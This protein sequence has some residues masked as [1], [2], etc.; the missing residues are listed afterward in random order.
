MSTW[1]IVLL[2][3]AALV[4][5]VLVL[6]FLRPKTSLTVRSALIDAPPERIYPF[7]ANFHAWPQWSPFEDMDADLKRE[8]GGAAEGVGATYAWEGRKAGAGSME[9]VETA[10]PHSVIIRLNFLKPFKAENRASFTIQPVAAGARVTWQ[11]TGP[12][13]FFFRLMGLFFNADRL[14]G[15]MFET[16]LARLKAVAESPSAH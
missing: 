2:V 10:P 16:G 9:I 3:V 1:Q 5:L 14:V 7:I 11:M 8:Y 12:S 15:G 4:A 6:A 13:P